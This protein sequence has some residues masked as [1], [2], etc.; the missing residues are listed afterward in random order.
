[1]VSGPV[2]KMYVY[3]DAFNE[4][5]FKVGLME[6]DYLYRLRQAVHDARSA[7]SAE[8]IHKR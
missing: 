2:N 1:M 3:L 4:V 6:S 5:V 7:G 8:A